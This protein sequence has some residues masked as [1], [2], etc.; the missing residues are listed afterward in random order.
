LSPL[1]PDSFVVLADIV[2][3]VEQSGAGEFAA[4]Y[5]DRWFI[6]MGRPGSD[7][8][9][10]GA[11]KTITVSWDSAELVFPLQARVWCVPTRRPDD[12]A[13]VS[14][15]R[16]ADNDIV[17]RDPAVS[18]QQAWIEARDDG[19]VLIDADSRNGTMIEGQALVAGEAV[20]LEDA[21]SICFGGAVTVLYCTSEG[22]C[23]L[24][25]SGLTGDG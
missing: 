7:D 1:P 19:D 17:M 25:E 9:V 4:Q 11:G 2:R 10:A 8:G 5:P 14:V 16:S 12:P 21:R 20:V 3:E 24:L 15:G 18:Q 13:R 23:A 6:E 22:L